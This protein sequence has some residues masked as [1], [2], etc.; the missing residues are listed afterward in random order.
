[1][2][3]QLPVIP[4]LLVDLPRP[5]QGTQFGFLPLEVRWV[6]LPP[7]THRS[8]H[9]TM[10]RRLGRSVSRIGAIVGGTRGNVRVRRR[11]VPRFAAFVRLRHTVLS[12]EKRRKR[13]PVF[14]SKATAQPGD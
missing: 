14:K 1:M 8:T 10:A 5:P 9:R 2:D 3:Y 6:P 11:L 4:S 12:R 13:G 7:P